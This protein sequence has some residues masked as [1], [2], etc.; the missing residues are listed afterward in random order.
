MTADFTDFAELS[1]AALY[2]AK[3]GS[4]SPHQLEAFRIAWKN[5][6]TA[7]RQQFTDAWRSN[8]PAPS[9][10]KNKTILLNVP[11]YSQRDSATAQGD[12]MC[13]SSTCAMAAEFLKPNCLA[14]T[15]QKDDKYLSILQCYGDTTDA[16]AQIKTLGSLG[17]KAAFRQDGGIEQLVKL[18]ARGIPIPVGWLHK[19]SVDNPSGGGHWSLV[20]GWDPENK[21][22]IMHDPYGE[23][24][25][26][27]GGYVNT[28]IGSGRNQRYSER[29][30][31]RRWMINASN[32]FQPGTGWYIE[33]LP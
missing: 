22:V 12:R 16:N 17:L 20:I 24:N 11:Y 2:V 21:E 29:N 8:P 28:A 15:K 9:L 33:F 10:N 5:M 19:G 31:G 25:L 13:F 14:G 32:H 3:K 4:V 30:W 18:L 26:I 23:A 27:G 6:T 1:D 7:Q